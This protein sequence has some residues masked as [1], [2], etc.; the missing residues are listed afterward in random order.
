MSE[1]E[2]R[3][4]VIRIA[5]TW[6]GLPYRDGARIRGVCG[7]CTFL[8][9]VYEDAGLMPHIDI[10]DYSPQAHLHRAGSLYIDAVRE[11]SHETDD[12]KPGDM[13]L[14]FFG[15]AFSHGAIII[16][17]GWPEIIHGDRAAKFIVKSHGDQGGLLAAKDRKF[18]T[19]W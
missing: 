8:A 3:A 17:P 19:L 14:Y 5:H 9:L 7:D 6:V 1:Q 16:E 4:E 2:E 12:P 11:H 13:V 18:F 15:R 10:P